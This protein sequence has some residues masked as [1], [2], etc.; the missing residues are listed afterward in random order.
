ML[1]AVVLN[2][3]AVRGQGDILIIIE[4]NYIIVTVGIDRDALGTIVLRDNSAVGNRF[5]VRGE[6]R[7]DG[8]AA[9]NIIFGD[10]IISVVP[11]ISDSAACLIE[12]EVKLQDEAAVRGDGASFNISVVGLVIDVLAVFLIGLV[13]GGDEYGGVGLAR[14]GLAAVCGGGIFTV[15]VLVV[16]LDSVVHVDGFPDGVEVVGAI[17]VQTGFGAC[18]VVSRICVS[19]VCP[20]LELVAGTGGKTR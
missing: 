7:A 18:G 9:E 2:G 3:V 10:L 12:L 6:S 8:L 1:L 13:R 4:G 11:E 15:S 17:V 16:E 20:A 5:G 14:T 19:R